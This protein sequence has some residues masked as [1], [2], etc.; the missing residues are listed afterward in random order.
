MELD[1]HLSTVDHCQTDGLDRIMTAVSE[2]LKPR[3][4]GGVRVVGSWSV[5]AP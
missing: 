3:R 4:G 1:L 5:I 2:P